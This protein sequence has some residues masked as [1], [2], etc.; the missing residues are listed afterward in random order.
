[1]TGIEIIEGRMST[2]ETLLVRFSSKSVH[3]S[4]NTRTGKR[5]S[6]TSADGLLV[7]ET[8]L[9]SRDVLASARTQGT[10]CFLVALVRS[11]CLFH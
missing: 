6:K 4:P 11:R 10:A 2:F 9:E 1:M 7:H 8:F 3:I 5:Q